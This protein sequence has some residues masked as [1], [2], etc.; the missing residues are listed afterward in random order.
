MNLETLQKKF[1]F[2]CVCQEIQTGEYIIGII[3]N[4]T[5]DMINI[6]SYNSIK[7]KTMK[8]IFL[9]LGQVW[10]WESNRRIPINLFLKNDFT[11][12]KPILKRY[13]NKELKILSGYVCQLHNIFNKNVKR[14]RINITNQCSIQ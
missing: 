14:K 3:Q 12:F 1:P 11:K 5:K 4:K 8:H 6:Y 9:E 7:S 13:S 10:W 2:L